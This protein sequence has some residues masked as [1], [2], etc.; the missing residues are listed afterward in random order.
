MDE[1]GH[2]LQAYHIDVP[3][4]HLERQ[5][6]KVDEGERREKNN[7]WTRG[8]NSPCTSPLAEQAYF[9]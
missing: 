1:R 4:I 6:R 9:I 8:Q 2:L 3:P 5:I 7:M